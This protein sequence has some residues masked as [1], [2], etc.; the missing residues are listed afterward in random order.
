MNKK[1]VLSA[2]LALILFSPLAF[3]A[4]VDELQ[5]R[6]E[7]VSSYKANFEQTVTTVAGK[8]VQNGSGTFKVK[9]PNLFRLD[10][11]T[12]QET[13]IIAD[14]KTL[15]Y[16]D[17]FVQ[18]VTAKKVD[19][20]IDNTP[21]ILLTSNDPKQWQQYEVTQQGDNFILTPKSKNS[22]IK[23]FQLRIDD[24][25]LLRHF[26]TVEQD[27]Q[28]NLYQLRNMNNLPIDSKEFSFSVPKGVELDDQR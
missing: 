22:A 17:P 2:T 24:K 12:P 4:A 7:L 14:G 23:Q 9:R 3:S 13:Q 5:Q 20:A 1:S 26:S 15:W 27:G 16:Y 25:G 6:L 19:D 21:F 8:V 10:T 18:Q 28:S 11:T